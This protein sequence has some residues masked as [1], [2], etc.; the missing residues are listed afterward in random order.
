MA[1][2]QKIESSKIKKIKRMNT[3][4]KYPVIVFSCKKYLNKKISAD[5]N[6][7]FIADIIKASIKFSFTPAIRLFIFAS[8][9]L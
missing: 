7:N 6:D 5:K 9:S 2:Y 1:G 8:S 4:R 3:E